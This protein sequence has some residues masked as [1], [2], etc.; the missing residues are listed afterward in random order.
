MR[1]A[2]Y[3]NRMSAMAAPH[4]AALVA[5]R[6]PPAAAQAPALEDRSAI[7]GLHAIKEAMFSTTGNA[8]W[9]PCSLRHGSISFFLR[10]ILPPRHTFITA[11]S[12]NE[13]QRREDATCAARRQMCSH[14]T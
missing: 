7:L 11:H 12:H 10:S 9:L 5:H 2:P 8:F 3:D 4:C 14:Y 6:Q 1:R 13:P